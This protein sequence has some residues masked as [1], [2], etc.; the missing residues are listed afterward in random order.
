[1][2]RA[3]Q[4]SFAALAAALDSGQLDLSPGSD[5]ARA[6]EVMAGLPGLGP[7]RREQAAGRH[8]TLYLR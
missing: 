8:Q 4:A 6:R 2:P 5:W 3:R 7:W 1:M